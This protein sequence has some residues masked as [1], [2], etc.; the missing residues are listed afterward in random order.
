MVRRME[1]HLDTLRELRPLAWPEPFEFWRESEGASPHWLG[2]ARSRGFE[3]WEDWRRG[4]FAPFRMEERRWTLYQV[5]GD[6]LDIVPRW[7]GGPFQGW[8][9]N[10]YGD[11]GPCPNF[12][13]IAERLTDVQRLYVSQIMA[14]FPEPTTVIGVLTDDGIVIAEGMHRCSAV[15]ALSAHGGVTL[16]TD[17]RI[18]LGSY[19]PGGVPVIPKIFRGVTPA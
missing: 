2:I 11:A 16:T 3:T 1:K 10:T 18:A 13:T 9:E 14:A 15:A 5:W 19:L 17:F 12:R 6:I 8:I 4:Y 7:H